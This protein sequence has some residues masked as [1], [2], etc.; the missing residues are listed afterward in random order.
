MDIIALMSEIH[1]SDGRKLTRVQKVYWEVVG[2]NEI[3]VLYH[4]PIFVY[5]EQVLRKFSRPSNTKF[6]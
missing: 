5:N 3:C 4:V 1:I 6:N 2:L